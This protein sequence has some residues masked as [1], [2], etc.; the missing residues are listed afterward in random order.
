MDIMRRLSYLLAAGLLL[1]LAAWFRFGNLADRPV[2][3]D[4]ANQAMKAGV[5]LETGEYRYDPHEH[6]GPTLY[7]LTLPVLWSAGI[8]TIQEANI[9]YFRIVPAIFGLLVVA[10]TFLFA[11]WLGR[12][13][14]LWAAAF[15]AISHSM[16]FYS[17]YY[18]QEMLFVCFALCFVYASFRFI[19]TLGPG[20][21]IALGAAAGLLHATKETCVLVFLAWGAAVLVTLL[22][23]WRKGALS[24][25]NTVP[26]G[27]VVRKV[28]L[29]LAVAVV[30]SFVLFSSFL[31]WWRGPLDSLLTYGQY[32]QRAEGEGSTALHEQPFWYYFSLL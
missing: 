15:T 5:L 25:P 23:A 22:G 6:H 18:V 12:W 16:V 26:A 19:E 29:A 13:A 31:T 32:V 1:L 17:Q 21:A 27:Q 9:V 2:H 3:G 4:E 28:M 8:K 30:V 7:Y 11:R 20:W 14:V 24:G 10:G